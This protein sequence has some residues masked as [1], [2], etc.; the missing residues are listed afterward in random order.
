[1]VNFIS[2]FITFLF[3]IL[4]GRWMFFDTNESNKFFLRGATTNY[5]LYKHVPIIGILAKY[6]LKLIESKFNYWLIK[7]FGLFCILLT[8]L[9][10]L[11]L[12]SSMIF[13]HRF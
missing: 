10:L 3:L 13:P 5:K 4:I 12:L 8:L 7:I 2:E 6:N 11:L 1:M 9:V